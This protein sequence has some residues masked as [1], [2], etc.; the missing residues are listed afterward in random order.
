MALLVRRGQHA[1][2]RWETREAVRAGKT[3]QRA[4]KP[5]HHGRHRRRREQLTP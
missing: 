2:P 4:G 1:A 3:A 5:G